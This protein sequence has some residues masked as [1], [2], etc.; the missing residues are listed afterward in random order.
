M[1]NAKM[2]SLTTSLK[3]TYCILFSL[4]KYISLSSAVAIS[5]KKPLGGFQKL[6]ELFEFL[7]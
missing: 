3:Y 1:R 4:N 2:Y 5:K 6:L 7:L